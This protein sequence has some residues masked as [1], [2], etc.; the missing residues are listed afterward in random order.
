MEI[1]QLDRGG[2]VLANQE[3]YEN[4]LAVEFMI[5]LRNLN[6]KKTQKEKAV[7]VYLQKAEILM[8][9]HRS[10][11]NDW[12]EQAQ[13]ENAPDCT[14]CCSGWRELVRSCSPVAS[15][16][17]RVMATLILTS[18][19]LYRGIIQLSFLCMNYLQDSV[20]CV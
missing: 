3:D 1:R 16:L 7:H 10:S 6:L 2:R 17:L 9:Q 8:L 14:P 15:S 20:L 12:K 19:R 4:D 13:M 11:N 18:H 5:L